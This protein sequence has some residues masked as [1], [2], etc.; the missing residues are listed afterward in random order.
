MVVQSD[1]RNFIGETAKMMSGA[2]D[3][4]IISHVYL[5]KNKIRF[6]SSPPDKTKSFTKVYL[7]LQSTQLIGTEVFMTLSIEHI[8]LVVRIAA[9]KWPCDIQKSLLKRTVFSKLLQA[10]CVSN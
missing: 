8:I 4:S 3:K 5:L 10:T 7:F 2:N 6:T 1:G 9:I